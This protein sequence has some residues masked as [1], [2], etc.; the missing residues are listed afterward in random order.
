MKQMIDDLLIFTRTRLGDTLPVSFTPQDLGRICN[1]AIDEVCA[2]Y[3][4]ARIRLRVSGEVRGRWDGSR[5]GQM[6]VNR[7]TNAVRY[8][9]GEIAVEV[10]GSN[11]RVTLVVANEGN[12][13]PE[14]L[15][16]TL[17][18]PLTRASSP[19]S[20]GTAVGMGL[21]LYI[22]RCIASAHQ[23]TID[24]ESSASGTRF[25]VS[26]PREAAS[27]HSSRAP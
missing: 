9:A 26:L 5:L 4:D 11:D 18:D 3:P 16:P 2:S 24:V 25:T 21:G 10:E 19:D 22:C 12:P 1:D 7:L 15:L 14:Q 8:G 23:G 27:S 17:F 20:R 6:V 13:I